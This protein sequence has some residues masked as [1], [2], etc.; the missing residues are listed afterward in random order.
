MIIFLKQGLPTRILD[1]SGSVFCN[2]SKIVDFCIP[3]FKKELRMPFVELTTTIRTYRH[4][5]R[6]HI[7]DIRRTSRHLKYVCRELRAFMFLSIQLKCQCTSKMIIFLKQG[8]P[9]RILDISGACFAILA[10]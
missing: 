8:L 9:T 3:Q 2:F 10:K 1:I 5:N 4:I 7:E 6:K